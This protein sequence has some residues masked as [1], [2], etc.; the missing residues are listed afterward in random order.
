M[1]EENFAEKAD[2]HGDKGEDS[3]IKT[4]LS[5]LLGNSFELLLE[6]C[7]ILLN[8]H[9]Q[10]SASNEGIDTNGYY[11]GLASTSLNKSGLEKEW[12]GVVWVGFT[13]AWFLPDWLWLSGEVSFI[14]GEII[15]C[16]HNTVSWN[17]VSSWDF[18]DV[19]ND[20]LR[21]IN[22]FLLSIT[23]NSGCHNI[24]LGLEF[25]EL[26]LLDP[27]V[28]NSDNDNDTDGN[29]NGGSIDPT[30]GPAIFVD[31]DSHREDSCH[32]KDSHDSVIKALDDHITDG[33]DSSFQWNISSISKQRG[34]VSIP[35]L[36]MRKYLS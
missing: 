13:S 28:G 31:S 12:V 6:W 17:S 20:K 15:C 7:H 33:P 14:G 5:N 19:S 26:L 21:G 36:K 8:V 1:G 27:V 35:K 25:L 3:T 18:D 10:T 32:T 30:M 29:D 4:S 11:D 22:S 9:G 23:D 24:T 2:H 16:D 34:R